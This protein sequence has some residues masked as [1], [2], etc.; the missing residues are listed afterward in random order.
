MNKFKNNPI[1]KLLKLL[2]GSFVGNTDAYKQSHYLMYQEKTTHISSYIEPR[3]NKEGHAQIMFFGLQ[4]FIKEY[5]SDQITHEMINYGEKFWLANGVP[6]NRLGWEIIVNEYNGYIPVRIQAL[7][8]GTVHPLGVPQVQVC[9]V[10]D[11]RLKWV[12]GLIETSLLR[13]VWYPSSVA[14]TSWRIKQVIREFLEETSDIPEIVLPTRLHDFG[15]RGASSLETAGIGGCAHVVNFKGSDTS[16]G[17]LD[18]MIYYTPEDELVEWLEPKEEKIPARSIPASEH[19]PT[20][21][22]GEDREC[23]FMENLIVEFGGEGKYFAGVSD[24]YDLFRAIT[25]YW[26]GRLK[27]KVMN[28]GGTLVIRPDSGDP[29]VIPIQVIE[30]LGEIFGYTINQKGYKVLPN[31]VRVIQG[32]GVQEK[33]I[34][35]ILQKLKDLGWSAENIA[36]GMGGKLLQ[37][38][39]RDTYGYAMK[40]NAQKIEGSDEWLPV[41]K[42][43]KTDPMKNSKAGRQAVYGKD[44]TV[45]TEDQLPDGETN[46][47][48][49]VWNTGVM[50]VEHRFDDVRVRAD[51]YRTYKIAA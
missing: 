32:D 7:A 42:K 8:E 12:A 9:N 23:D 19:G 40:V 36:F 10:D 17:I 27:T 33:T 20:T 46:L 11:H 41:Q 38:I 49:D 28:N 13:G 51:S 48:T 5:L 35:I 34:R 47:L 21:S 26:G 6:F 3:W 14:T 1:I 37:S 18:A 50:L 30:K 22:W 25:E 4:I 44:F 31:C 39:D 43:P 29:T 24:S 16:S 45:C 2:K 15:A